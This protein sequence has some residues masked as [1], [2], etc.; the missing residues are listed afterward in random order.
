MAAIAWNYYGDTCNSPFSSPR[1]GSPPSDC[2]ARQ[3]GNCREQVFFEDWRWSSARA[4]LA[5]RDD[6]VVKI[7][8]A[9]ER[10]GDFA[11][12]LGEPFDEATT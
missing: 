10:V 11:A 12:F 4:H 5:G 6:H 2:A 8:L 1:H 9:I 3:R 7:A